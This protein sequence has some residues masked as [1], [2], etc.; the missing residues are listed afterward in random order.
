MVC[1]MC[2]S[3]NAVIGK[4]GSKQWWQS[5]VTEMLQEETDIPESDVDTIVAYL[6]KN[7]P[8]VKINVNKGA[9]KDL[10]D[11]A[12][13]DVQG[14]GSDRAVSRGQGEFQDVRRFE[15]SAGGGCGEDRI[16]ERPAGILM[17]IERFAVRSRDGVEIS[18]QKA[19]SG[20]ALLLVHGSLLNGAMS[21][22][23]VLPTLAERFTVYAMDRRG[24]APSGDAK[25]Y[26]IANEADD[27]ASVVEQSVGRLRCVAHSYGALATLEALDRLKTV[28]HLILYEPP[29][30]LKPVDTDAVVRPDG[31]S[32]RG[33]RSRKGCH[34]ISARSNSSAAG[35]YRDDAS[36]RPSGRSCFR[37][38]PRC[39]ASPAR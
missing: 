19:G 31:P 4:Q 7:F 34:D 21:W 13:V 2:H 25:Q 39:R 5:K 35:T 36:R 26:S 8:I 30:T 9:A 32:I 6:A 22:G 28:S 18:V 1:S 17:A 20:P 33:Q 29:V 10:R 3:P 38:L 37:L 24:R 15:E 11:R 23:R 12:G 16:E 27:I 14:I